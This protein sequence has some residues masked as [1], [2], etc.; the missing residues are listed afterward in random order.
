MIKTTSALAGINS[1]LN[2]AVIVLI[3]A[4]LSSCDKDHIKEDQFTNW[5]AYFHKEEIRINGVYVSTHNDYVIILI[6]YEDGIIYHTYRHQCS[7]FVSLET[8]LSNCAPEKFRE[9]HQSWGAFDINDNQFNFQTFQPRA[10]GQLGDLHVW[11]YSGSIINDSTLVIS[12]RI[13]HRDE[14]II[15]ADTFRFFETK[16]KPDSMNVLISE[17]GSP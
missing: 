3:S 10:G 8:T 7:P 16:F 5:G 9:V 15:K 14:V 2:T 4:L 11:Q 17:L 13:D 1:I 12:N 6:P